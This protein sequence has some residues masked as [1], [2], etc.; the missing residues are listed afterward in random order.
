MSR[1]SEPKRLAELRKTLR[2]L[3]NSPLLK[4]HFAWGPLNSFIL[5]AGAV[6]ASARSVGEFGATIVRAGNVSGDTRTIPVAV[7]TLLNVRGGEAGAARLVIVSIAL[8][9]LA[10][11]VSFW[12]SARQRHA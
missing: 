8:S 10:L 11:L 1:Q 4:N 3:A 9:M 2:Q 12:L 5:L 6:L 7:Y